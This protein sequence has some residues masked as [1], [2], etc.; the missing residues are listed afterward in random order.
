MSEP[1]QRRV[2][3]Y[4]IVRRLAVGGMAE[5]FLAR[6]EAAHGFTKQVVLKR[7]LPHLC[8]DPSFIEMFLYEARLAARLSHPNIAQVFDIG[9]SDERVYYAMEYV[10]GAD[11]RDVA[12]RIDATWNAPPLELV[13]GVCIGVAAGLH[14][15][16]TARDETGRPLAIVHRDVSPANVVVTYGGV[17]KLL[18]FGVAKA[19]LDGKESTAV[20][21]LKGK[22]PYMSP[23]QIDCSVA[24]DSRSDVFSLG[25][26]LWELTTLQRLYRCDSQMET[27][28]RITRE[29]A[30][31][32]S[33][34]RKDYPPALE[35]IVLRALARDRDQRYASAFE[36][37]RALEAFALDQQLVVSPSRIAELM[38][39]LFAEELE[40]ERAQLEDEPREVTDSEVFTTHWSAEANAA[41]S[42]GADQHEAP[43]R[44]SVVAPSPGPAVPGPTSPDDP[45]TRRRQ[46][47][48]W[49]GG[50]VGG[51]LL[52]ALTWKLAG[53]AGSDEQPRARPEVVDSQPPEQP[54]EPSPA[55]AVVTPPAQPAPVAQPASAKPAPPSSER[56]PD[57]P[58]QREPKRQ[59][60]KT[61]K[62]D[63]NWNKNSLAL[64]N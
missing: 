2:G 12:K 30:P 34:V 8:E 23:E 9:E 19:K 56:P 11:L 15:A 48:P 4:R 27:I 43:T 51:A 7:L 63:T 44:L 52:V 49:I 24:L 28:R 42:G 13:I 20:G 1:A 57:K 46:P 54:P 21:V 41:P 47:W 32:P 18:D 62:P 39:E 3:S 29:D 58:K 45:S 37:Q 17:A 50:A 55:P 5:I 61:S 25:V 16:H 31:P 14:Y 38:A 60:K 33:G 59:T 22:L 10:H 64:P 40:G 53:N 6:L 35:K 36:L 26:M